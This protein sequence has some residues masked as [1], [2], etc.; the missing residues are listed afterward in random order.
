MKGLTH[1]DFR[2]NAIQYLDPWKSHPSITQIHLGNN[3]VA[4][5]GQVRH[6]ATCSVLRALNLSGNPV[7]SQRPSLFEP[8]EQASRHANARYAP[9][10]RLATVFAVQQLT[11]L[12]SYP[13]SSEEKIASVNAYNPPTHVITSTHHAQKQIWLQQKH[14]SINPVDLGH[15]Q[16]MRPLVLFGPTG[17]GKR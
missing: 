12:D 9:G 2:N 8:V 13:V 10:Y 17:S 16:R 1:A 15:I 7:C 5:F 6:L 3:L 11:V 4:D 14:A